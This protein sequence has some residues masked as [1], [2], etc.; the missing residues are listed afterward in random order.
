MTRNTTRSISLGLC[1]AL[2]ATV[3][4]LAADIPLKNWTAPPTYT[5]AIDPKGSP[6]GKRT[7]RARSHTFR[8]LRAGNTARSA[9]H[10]CKA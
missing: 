5:P 6:H 8:P 9:R 4:L 1:L 2:L 3:P 7:S 10:F